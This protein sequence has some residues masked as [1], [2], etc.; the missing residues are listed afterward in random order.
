MIKIVTHGANFHADDVFAV[1]LLNIVHKDE[2]IKVVRTLDIEEH[3]DAKYIVDIGGKYNP[4][5]GFFDHHQKGGAGA[6]PNGIMYASFGLVWKEFGK[7][8]TGSS[9][10]ADWV[11]RN[12]VQAI[13]AMDTGTYTYTPTFADVSPFLFQDYIKA[14]CDLVKSDA[15]SGK[16]S[17]KKFDKEFM[18]MVKVAKDAIEVYV[19]KSKQKEIIYKKAKKAYDKAINKKIIIADEF[20]PSRF[21]EFT[22][23]PNKIPYVFIYPDLRGGWS[24]KVVPKGSQTYDSYMTFPEAWR[25]KSGQELA[26]ITGVKDAKFCHNAGFLAVAESKTGAIELVNNAFRILN[27]K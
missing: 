24:A 16:S 10:A 3:S 15:G 20:I 18:R 17:N 23:D 13:D 8:L 2:K 19:E 21:D 25:G 5:K 12:M 6:R 4:K 11:D 26:D 1:A 14:V 7:K 27:I 9:Y 22:D